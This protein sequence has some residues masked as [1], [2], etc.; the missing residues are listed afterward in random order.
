[1]RLGLDD[2]PGD[3]DVVVIAGLVWVYL[4][5]GLQ[6]EVGGWY[7]WRC[8]LCTREAV[9]RF[10]VGEDEGDAG[11]GEGGG[12]EG[13]DEGL[14]VGTWELVLSGVRRRGEERRA[15]PDP[16]MRTTMR[17]ALSGEVIVVLREI[18]WV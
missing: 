1:M 8:I 13:V 10:A 11:G 3:F 4:E 9:R 14:E 12:V 15:V 6:R 17:R 7:G 16:E 2:E 18:G 5:V